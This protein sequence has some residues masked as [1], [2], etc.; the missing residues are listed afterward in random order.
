MSRNWIEMPNS[1]W[2]LGGVNDCLASIQL[3][4]GGF[5]FATVT[6]RVSESFHNLNEA[7]QW[8]ESELKDLVDEI[9]EAV[10]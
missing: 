9:Q 8:C 7:Q 4:R 5:Y 2:F 3:N 6:T 10:G 1:R